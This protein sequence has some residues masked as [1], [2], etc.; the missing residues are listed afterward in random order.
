[1]SLVNVK[2]RNWVVYSKYHSSM[3]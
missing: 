3:R 2:V 1:M